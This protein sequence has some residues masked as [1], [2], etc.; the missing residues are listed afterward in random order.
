M[1]R[2]VVG[3][4]TA[5]VIAYALLPWYG[6]EDGLFSLGWLPG[7]PTHRAAGSGLVQ[8]LLYGRLSLLPVA[9]FL[10]AFKTNALTGQSICVS[11]GWHMS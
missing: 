11:H 6:I 10:A 8:S 3:W 2:G 9:L 7:Y 4:A 5:G 1:D